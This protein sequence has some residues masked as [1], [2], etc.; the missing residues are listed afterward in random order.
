M[1]GSERTAVVLGGT[2]LLGGAVAQR[3]AERGWRVTITG[4]RPPAEVPVWLGAARYVRAE[5][6][7]TKALATVIGAGCD[8]VVDALCF[9]ADDASTLVSLARDVTS[10]VM[11]S[12]KAVYV[13]GEGRHVNS[14]SHPRFDGPIRESQPTMAPG[15]GPS[16]TREGYGANKV[17]AERVLL[18]SG[19]PVSVLRVS[20]AHGRGAARP[21]EWVFV[22]RLL[23]RRRTLVLANRG[24]GTDHTS[25]AA[26][27]AALVEVVAERPGA[28]VLNA[29]D[30]SAPSGA[31]IARAVAGCLGEQFD[32]VLLEGD[33]SP[34]IGDHP[35]NAR[36]P[37]V[38]D[39]SAAGELGY[40]AVGTYDTLVGE[41]VR[42]LVALAE[43]RGLDGVL[44]DDER[45]YFA[46]YF[47]YAAE[48]AYLSGLDA[49]TRG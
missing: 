14:V 44:R 13:D 23:E 49:P 11:L 9:T 21:R 5:R 38:L 37:V 4:R 35:W 33:P 7:D 8:L 27:V 39:L 15:A 48:D 32:E 12:S 2:G 16:H 24:D 18:D 31:E 10:V 25:A 1:A 20:K 45:S 41:E 29:A 3:L 17:A 22:R 46:P 34:P 42:W 19:L 47:D 40:V 28:R 43:E 26:N 30:P 36:W 6:A